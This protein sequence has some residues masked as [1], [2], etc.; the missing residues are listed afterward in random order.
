MLAF[1]RRRAWLLP[2]IGLLAFAAVAVW[3]QFRIDRPHVE[4]AKWRTSGS[5]KSFVAV[6]VRFR[7][8]EAAP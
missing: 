4:C 8:T 7:P 6:C 3:D 5:G 2:L 1:V